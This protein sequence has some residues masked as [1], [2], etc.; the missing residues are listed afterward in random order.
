MGTSVL[1]TSYS[2]G[3]HVSVVRL[4][5]SVPFAVLWAGL[6]LAVLRGGR[7][8]FFISFLQI[9]ESGFLCLLL[10]LIPFKVTGS[11][12]SDRNL[13]FTSVFVHFSES[14]CAL[15]GWS[16]LRQSGTP[17][18]VSGSL[19]WMEF[20]WRMLPTQLSSS[21]PLLPLQVTVQGCE[22]PPALP[23]S[24]LDFHCCCSVS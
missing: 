14:L 3:L 13:L 1:V 21:L 22:H 4:N 20:H 19:S 24:A 11:G 8:E 17:L 15:Q 9:I 18:L 6:A 16:V 5:K 2:S 23:L 10:F 12:S 7:Q